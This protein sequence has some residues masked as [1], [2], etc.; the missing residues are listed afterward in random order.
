MS[1][2]LDEIIKDIMQS[3]EFCEIVINVM[4]NGTPKCDDVG[5]YSGYNADRM[6]Y[7]EDKPLGKE[8][9]AKL[10]ELRT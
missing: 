8:L 5:G 2:S 4:Q 3:N 6:S 1:R 9:I 7:I 10:K